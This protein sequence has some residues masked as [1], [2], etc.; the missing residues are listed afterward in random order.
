MPNLHFIDYFYHTGTYLSNIYEIVFFSSAQRQKHISAFQGCIL[1]IIKTANVFCRAFRA[2][3]NISTFQ[4]CMLLFLKRRTII[5]R[6][7]R[8]RRHGVKILIN[9]SKTMGLLSKYIFLKLDRL[10]SHGTKI[11]ALSI[12]TYLG[13]LFLQ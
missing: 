10:M 11:K 8:V 7:R 3:K 4:G 1:L 9:Y 2:K 13:L 5:C 6:A 12:I